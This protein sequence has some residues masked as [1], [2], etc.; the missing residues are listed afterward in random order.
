MKSHRSDEEQIAHRVRS[1]VKL[2]RSKK[3][4]PRDERKYI[5]S[6]ATREKY[7]GNLR[8][9]AKWLRSNK[10]LSLSDANVGI[11]V[12]YLKILAKRVVQKTVDGYRESIRLLCDLDVPYVQSKKPTVIKYPAYTVEQIKILC[13]NANPA[14]ALAIRVAYY[15]G[16]RAHELDTFG[17]PTDLEESDRKWIPERFEAREPCQLFNA[18]GK[19]KLTRGVML[20]CDIA[21][22]VEACRLPQPCEIKQRKIIYEKFYAIPGGQRFSQAFSRLSKRI[23]GWSTGAHGLRHRF[24]KERYTEFIKLGYRHDD[25]V[26]LLSQLLGHFSI[27][28]TLTYLR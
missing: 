18:P 27:K 24:A 4:L 12:I 25:A 15:G 11:A 22:E 6:I 23:F 28:N 8:R 17:R 9:F 5:A 2:G 1:K 13:D 10:N 16:L 7:E 21:E 20:P 19:G 3:G 14:L 26:K